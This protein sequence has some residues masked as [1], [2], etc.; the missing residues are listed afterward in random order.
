[1]T[2]ESSRDSGRPAGAGLAGSGLWLFAPVATVLFL[3]VRDRVFPPGPGGAS[4]PPVAPGSLAELIPLAGWE[5]QMVRGSDGARLRIRLEPL[6]PDARRQ[7]FDAEVLAERLGL[8]RSGI[9]VEEGGPQPWRLTLVAEADRAPQ[10]PVQGAPSDAPRPQGLPLVST[11]SGVRC[12]G[13]APVSSAGGEARAGVE[14]LSALLGVADAPLSVGERHDLILW[15]EA[16][17]PDTYPA[18]VVVPGLGETVLL[19][20]VRDARR[21]SEAVARTDARSASGFEGAR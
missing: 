12:P 8:E 5:G 4:A 1:M 13:L 21:R 11:L 6:H 3:A 15:G 2:T 20:D 19:P 18:V 9:P 17:G 16:P 10:P 7:A 14:V